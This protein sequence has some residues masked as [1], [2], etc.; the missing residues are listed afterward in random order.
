M[1]AYQREKWDQPGTQD[2]DYTTLDVQHLG[3]IY[4]GLLEL[5]PRIAVEAMVET[6]AD[7]KPIFK[8]QREVANPRPIRGQPP[9][10]INADEVYLVTN[11][12]ERKA[13]GSYYTPKYIVDY[14]VENPWAVSRRSER[15]RCRAAS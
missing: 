13:T 5:Q 8:P 9:R 4:E 2:I 6:V 11:R 1:L 15:A 10:M 3:S 14:I 7:G 12:G